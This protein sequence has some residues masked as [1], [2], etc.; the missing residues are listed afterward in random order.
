MLNAEF[1]TLGPSWIFLV[2]F[3]QAG[4]DRPGGD[5]RNFDLATPDAGLCRQECERD[6]RCRAF[7][8]VKPGVQGAAARCWLKETVPPVR[9]DS[10]CTSGVKGAPAQSAGMTTEPGMDRPGRDYRNFDLPRADANLC[11]EACRTDSKCLSYTYVKPGVQG[12]A[13]RCWLKETVAEGRPDSC[14]VSG[15]KGAGGGSAASSPGPAFSSE[16]G[17]DR[18]GGDYRSLDLQQSNPDLCR[19]ECQRDTAC[20]AYVYVKPGV[21]GSHA[22]CWL[23]NTVTGARR[24]ECCV[25]GVRTG[26]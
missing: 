10:C 14:C 18:P 24:D 23:K 26:R 1:G 2:A 25:S 4:T 13:A 5:Y 9:T 6:G 7:V 11:S 19:Q 12:P 16:S 20:A 15:V 17:T 22:R 3:L 8:Y 21:Q